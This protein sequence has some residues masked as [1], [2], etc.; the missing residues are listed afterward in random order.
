MKESLN[1]APTVE[2]VKKS[3]LDVMNT[4]ISKEETSIL[5]NVKN[6]RIQKIQKDKELKKEEMKRKKAKR[7][8]E[9]KGH[10]KN[11]TNDELEDELKSTAREGSKNS[12]K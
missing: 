1:N 4:I 10:E 3:M 11:S 2:P 9:E 7:N 12:L 8:E 5:S 6:K